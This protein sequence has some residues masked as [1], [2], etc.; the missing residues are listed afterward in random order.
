MK[1]KI[2]VIPE[3]EDTLVASPK[4]FSVTVNTINVSMLKKDFGY[5]HEETMKDVADTITAFIK[6]ITLVEKT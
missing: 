4:E 3:V 2:I 6:S 5:P 1:I